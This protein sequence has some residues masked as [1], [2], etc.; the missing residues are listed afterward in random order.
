MSRIPVGVCFIGAAVA[1]FL[2]WA[3]L[4]VPVLA[5][6]IL[7]LF[8]RELFPLRP[9]HG[10]AGPLGSLIL[11]YLAACVLIALA[12]GLGRLLGLAF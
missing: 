1:G 3:W 5:V 6:L 10:I 11:A 7:A 2:G 12:F 4:T 9:I 8:A